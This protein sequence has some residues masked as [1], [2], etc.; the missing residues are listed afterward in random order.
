VVIFVTVGNATQ[1]FQRLLDAVDALAGNGLFGYEQVFVQTGH[2]PD[3]KPRHGDHKPF[4]SIDEFQEWM[5]RADLIICH[6]GCGTLLHAVR[7]GKAPVVMPR[8]KKY[9]EHVNDH[10]VQLVQA[11]TAEGRVIP[12]YEPENL[13]A[14]VAEAGK[15][16]VKPVD[17]RPSRMV[18][19]VAQAVSALAGE[20]R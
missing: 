14:A 7:L 5:E 18:T 13:S 2:N 20:K 9:S 4:L 8:R 17:R 6:G 1:K 10:Q 3:F 19:L 15:R 11:F 12:A 16:G